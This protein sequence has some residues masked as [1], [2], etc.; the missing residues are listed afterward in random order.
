VIPTHFIAAGP[1]VTTVTATAV[2]ST[3]PFP[4]PAANPFTGSLAA[5]AKL[6]GA[7]NAAIAGGPGTQWRAAFCVV[8]LPNTDGTG[9]PCVMASFRPTENHYT[10]SL[11]KVHAMYAAFQLRETLRAIAVE[12][13][14]R[15][16]TTNLISLARPYLD[17][18]ILAQAGPILRNATLDPRSRS[19][20]TTDKI[21][22]SYTGFDIVSA[23]AG[24]GVTV[25]FT[26]SYQRS[27]EKM[28]IESDDA[29]ATT[30]IHNIGYGYLNGALA[31]A[32]FFDTSLQN[33]L[34][35]AGDYSFFANWG[36]LTI[37]TVNDGKASAVATVV[38]LANLF[39]HIYLIGGLLY[40]GTVKDQPDPADPTATSAGRAR[41][42]MFDLLKRV[43]TA[44]SRTGSWT[45]RGN[46]T[47]GFSVWGSKLGVGDLK[48]GV[49][50]S[51]EAA[52]VIHTASQR[53]FVVAWQNFV[54]GRD[55]FAPVIH[56]IDNTL[57]TFLQP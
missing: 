46:L 29:E 2:L 44:P 11:A 40:T 52:I 24:P 25:N 20:V 48:S 28:I 21:L 55:A 54:L 9:P 10:A 45:D 16:T 1:K 49:S 53:R 33:G 23:S 15:A 51:S 56:V 38:Q 14:A 30:C 31:S 35:L 41:R 19:P 47:R 27:L 32:G 50:V 7:L 12:L 39:T 34:W 5:A 26:A 36:A 43:E 57:A 3:T 6:Q 8:S 13:G 42:D 17:P 22:P 4:A 18:L 37:D